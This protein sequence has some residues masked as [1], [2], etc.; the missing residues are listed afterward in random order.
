[1]TPPPRAARSPANVVVELP[2]STSAIATT[3]ENPRAIPAAVI[4]LTRSFRRKW[5]TRATIT[6]WEVTRTT[7]LATVT[8]A[9]FRDVIQNAKWAARTTP[10]PAI[11]STSRRAKGRDGGVRPL[12]AHGKTIRVANAGRENGGAGA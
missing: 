12:A 8:P 4:P 6:G 2:R 11:Q 3:P 5:D 9:V 7:E 10:I 1:M